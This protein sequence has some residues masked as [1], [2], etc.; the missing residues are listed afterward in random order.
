[1]DA[2]RIDKWLWAA[3][4]AKTRTAAQELCNG[5]HVTL[6]ADKHFKV[7]RIVRIGDELEILRGTVLFHV[8]IIGL[9]EKRGAP[10]AARLL[11]EHLDA[12]VNLNPPKAETF[13]RRDAKTGRPTKKDRRLINRLKGKI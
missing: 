3:R 5:G 10:A 11:Y 8:R 13:E 1:M 9:S 4:F 12:P 7:S 6:N 2:V